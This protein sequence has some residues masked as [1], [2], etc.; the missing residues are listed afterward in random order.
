MSTSVAPVRI[1]INKILL[2]TD[3]S[4][5]SARALSS[6]ARFARVFGAHLHLLHVLP[7][8]ELPFVPPGLQTVNGVALDSP[9]DPER[10]F[11]ALE[12]LHLIGSSSGCA[13]LALEFHVEEGDV[14]HS[15]LRE[16]ER[17]DIDLLVL[18]TH[19]RTGSQ[20]LVLGSVAQTIF[21]QAHCLVLTVGP[22]CCEGHLDRG[23]FKN[24]LFARQL[25][26]AG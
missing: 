14:C 10:R 13:D 9:N 1:S 5:C 17:E 3:F 20:K 21:E 18:G 15:V 6:A 25:F 23:G 4:S 11:D 24:I 2:A 8:N 12:G 16:I 19:G 22:A 26:A 7:A